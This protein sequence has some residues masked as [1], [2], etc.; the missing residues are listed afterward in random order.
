MSG[1]AAATVPGNGP[2]AAAPGWRRAWVVWVAAGLWGLLVWLWVPVLRDWAPLPWP[3][4]PFPSPDGDRSY[5]LVQPEGIGPGERLPLVFV[6]QGFDTVEGS[7]QSTKDLYRAFAARVADRRFIAV[8]PRGWP[9]AFP[10]VPEVRAWYPGHLLEN[11]AFLAS[12]AAHLAATLPA[13]PRRVV[14]AGFSNGGYFGGIE[15]LTNPDTPFTAFWFDGGAWPYG[16]HPA[17]PRRPIFLS[18]GEQD[19]YNRPNTEAFRGYL[20][21]NGWAEGA[22]LRTFRHG[23]AHVF[24][25]GALDEALTFL[26]TDHDGAGPGRPDPAGGGK[27]KEDGP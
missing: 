7:S 16:R 20:A 22:D 10:E 5:Y 17:A 24:A 4:R 6:L 2:G 27:G 13:D 12:L 9:G 8:F 15:A 25:R 1:C 14:L 26:L 23:G 11:R 3:E 18:W 21:A 19:L